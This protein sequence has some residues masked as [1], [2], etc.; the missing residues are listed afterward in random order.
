MGGGVCVLHPPDT[1]ALH[2]TSSVPEMD[3]GGIAGMMMEGPKASRGEA[4][5]VLGWF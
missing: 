1:S 2:P 5:T 4:S 3:L